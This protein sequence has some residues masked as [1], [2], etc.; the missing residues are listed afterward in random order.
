VPAWSDLLVVFVV[1]RLIIHPGSAGTINV[2]LRIFRSEGPA[3]GVCCATLDD[4]LQFVGHDRRAPPILSVGGTRLSR[5]LRNIGRFIAIRRARQACPS[6]SLVGGTCLS[7]PLRNIG[8]SIAI[9]RAR[10]ACPSDSLLGATQFT[11]KG[12]HRRTVIR[13][14]MLPFWQNS[15]LSDGP[16]IASRRSRL[17][18]AI[19]S[20]LL[21]QK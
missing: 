15:P 13:V 1:P 19:Q 3:R 16:S 11:G 14:R 5:P 4:P 8:R 21:F 10:Q 20:Q 2:P 7:G 18:A 9:R 6:D 12:C 17:T